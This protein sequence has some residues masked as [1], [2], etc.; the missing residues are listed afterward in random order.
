VPFLFFLPN[1]LI[2]LFAL[3]E[4]IYRPFSIEA[5]IF[6]MPGIARTDK[7]H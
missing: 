4:I 6:N 2:W 7:K 5:D 1:R 3:R